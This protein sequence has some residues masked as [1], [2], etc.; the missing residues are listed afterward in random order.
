MQHAAVPLSAVPSPVQ[1]ESNQRHKMTVTLELNQRE[2]TIVP[3]GLRTKS[4]ETRNIHQLNVCAPKINPPIFSACLRL[5]PRYHL[6]SLA[7]PPTTH[8]PIRP[9][10]RLFI[11]DSLSG[12]WCWCHGDATRSTVPARH[13][14]VIVTH[15]SGAPRRTA[16]TASVRIVELL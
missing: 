6:S 13:C 10:R 8:L 3:G 12:G 5:A 15:A 16:C 9:S 11:G 2:Q 4:T 14:L 1:R 7:A